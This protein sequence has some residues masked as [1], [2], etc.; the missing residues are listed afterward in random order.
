MSATVTLVYLA[1]FVDLEDDESKFDVNEL[2]RYG[3]ETAIEEEFTFP[4]ANAHAFH[5]SAIVDAGQRSER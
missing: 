4:S 2:A 3:V 5:Q 1:R